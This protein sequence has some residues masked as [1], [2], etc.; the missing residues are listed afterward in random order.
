M[1][2][3]LKEEAKNMICPK[4]N[5][6]DVRKYSMYQQEQKNLKKRSSSKGTL[7]CL[8]LI[9]FFLNPLLFIFLIV[10]VAVGASAGLT[11]AIPLLILYVIGVIALKTHQKDMYICMK[12]G[13][14]YKIEPETDD[15]E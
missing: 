10:I 7:G 6:E 1:L 15:S 14:R 11:V 2:I 4:C 9:L 12:C 13:N 5:S 8:G 3:T